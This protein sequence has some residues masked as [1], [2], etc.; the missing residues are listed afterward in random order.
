MSWQEHMSRGTIA[1]VKED[2]RS[3]ENELQ[4][5]LELAETLYGRE[6]ER[7]KRTLGLLGQ[8]ELRQANLDQADELL[9]RSV[10][11]ARYSQACN[12]LSRAAALM[13]LA[14]LKRQCGDAAG[15]NY[16]YQQAV[17]LLR[18]P[19]ADNEGDL[20]ST[21]LETLFS[22]VNSR[23]Q[24]E[25]DRRFKQLLVKARENY[26]ASRA[27]RVNASKEQLNKWVHQMQE[28]SRVLKSGWDSEL[29]PAYTSAHNATTIAY[30]I[31]DHDHPNIALSLIA[32]AD[33]SSRMHMHEQ[34]EQLL[35]RAA[36]IY[37]EHPTCKSELRSA[38]LH[39]ASF[40]ASISDY[41]NS[42]RCL[43]EASELIDTSEDVRESGSTLHAAL[44]LAVARTELYSCFRDTT[45]QA[46]EAEETDHLEHALLLYERAITLLKRIFPSDHLE[47]AQMLYF[48]ANVLRK[49]GRN[50]LAECAERDAELIDE[51][52]S[53]RERRW[54]LLANQ[55]PPFKIPP[56]RAS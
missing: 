18:M 15:A 9:T 17:E 27:T 5:A 31:F 7:V 54:L 21:K 16:R 14:S 1:L 2:Y 34:A 28:C 52:N 56:S 45:R 42:L 26:D 13:T 19:P 51:T 12:N 38:K 55:V 22:Q 46:I 33:C 35:L 32:L 37:G 4:K 41:P 43:C 40:Y 30:R 47:L 11:N 48:K 23:Q 36:T 10:E 53:T 25:V 29:I 3:A 24:G 6:D 44:T 49:L 20:A 8:V 50:D 39:L